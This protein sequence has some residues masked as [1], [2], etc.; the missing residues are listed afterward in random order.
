MY[1]LVF[2]TVT[3][4]PSLSLLVFRFQTL[5]S[6]FSEFEGNIQKKYFVYIRHHSD[7][8]LAVCGNRRAKTK[9]SNLLVNH[10]TS[11]SGKRLHSMHI[12]FIF[13]VIYSRM[14]FSLNDI[15]EKLHNSLSFHRHSPLKYHITTFNSN[16]YW[17]QNIHVFGNTILHHVQITSYLRCGENGNSFILII[18]KFP[19]CST[20]THYYYYAVI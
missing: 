13:Y 15:Y 8:C 11:R 12:N 9:C 5:Q 6:F 7:G 1:L 17:V 3:Y 10:L 20:R 18:Y 4:F 19:V 2:L 14:S 16:Y